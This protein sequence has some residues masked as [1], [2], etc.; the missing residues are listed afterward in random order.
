MAF[1][2]GEDASSLDF[3]VFIRGAVGNHAILINPG[4]GALLFE[5]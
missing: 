3:A 1:P 4:R 2:I 5:D